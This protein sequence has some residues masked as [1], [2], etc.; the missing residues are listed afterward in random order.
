MVFAN[1][2]GPPGKGYAGLSQVTVPFVGP[3]GRLGSAKEGMLIVD[4]EGEILEDAEE[5]YR[6]R[7]D[8]ARSDWHYEYRHSR[9]DEPRSGDNEGPRDQIG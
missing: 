3:L 5:C 2:G 7:S 6:V 8:I 4:V 1:A 9:L